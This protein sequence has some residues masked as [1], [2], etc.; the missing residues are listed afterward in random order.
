V[1]LERN[2]QQRQAILAVINA[3]PQ[4][5]TPP[6]ILALASRQSPRLGI[7]TVYRLI[8]LLLSQNLITMVEIPGQPPRYER[9][10]PGHHHHFLCEN[11]GNVF[12][13]GTCLPNINSIAPPRFKVARHDLI[14][15]GECDNCVR[16]DQLTD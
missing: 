5:L 3:S 16:T 9:Q 2:T 7:A 4:P 1:T 12:E 14:L 15:Y 13:L 8:R 10:S 6:Q 11:C